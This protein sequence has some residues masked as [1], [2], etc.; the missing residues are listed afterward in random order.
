MTQ[1]STPPET[2]I[3]YSHGLCYASVCAPADM[4]IELIERSA[5]LQVPT[6]VGPWKLVDESFT[7]G[8]TNPH[9]CERGP[10]HLHYL[11]AC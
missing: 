9:D 8:E 11:L 6:G 7:T 2:P 10:A 5:N 4:S 3:V 1:V